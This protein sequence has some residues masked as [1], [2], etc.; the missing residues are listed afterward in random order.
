MKKKTLGIFIDGTMI[1]AALVSKDADQLIVEKVESFKLVEAIEQPKSMATDKLGKT[2]EP[3]TIDFDDNPWQTDESGA[4]SNTPV[5]QEEQTNLDIVREILN[6]MCPKGTSIAF[7][8]CES[9]VFYKT[10]QTIHES[11][12]R[13][14]KEEIWN[15]FYE[16]GDAKPHLENVGFLQQNSGS[17]VALIHND[18]LTL[19]SLLFEL[20]N[21]SNI[22]PPRIQLVD[23]I[24]FTLAHEI[25]ETLNIEE[26]ETS[27]VV[28]FSKSFT[29]VFFM[30]GEKI[31]TVLPPILEGAKSE[32]VCETTFSK[33]LFEFSSG[34]IGVITRMVLMGEYEESKA[35]EFFMKKFPNLPIQKFAT[36]RVSISPEIK[37]TDHLNQYALPILLAAKSLD[38]KLS[39]PYNLNFLPR[40]IQDK[41]S[42]YKIAWHGIAMLAIV[43][44]CAFLMTMQ[45]VKNAQHISK[46]KTDISYLKM[47]AQQL[48]PVENESDSLLA[49]ISK[50]EKQTSLLDSLVKNTTRWS[51][52]LETF[53]NAYGKI[54]SFSL[55][56]LISQAHNQLIADAIMTKREQV[57]ELERAINNSMILNVTETQSDINNALNLQIQCKVEKGN[58]Q[59]IEKTG[60]IKNKTIK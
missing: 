10:I 28:F 52:A 8:L 5:L 46:T 47:T 29:K 3:E 59:E 49:N 32:K 25:K 17:L 33:I 23:S 4:E 15:I 40:R 45:L 31:I 7:N 50:L 42:V 37:N 55:K 18:P 16:E 38:K 53:S 19:S 56:S 41:Q 21:I 24:E 20:K 2:D 51:P 43:F 60:Q 13:K 26:E 30:H 11:R 9:H 27:L 1:R 44:I 48:A 39:A 35:F 6:K 36:G 57:A 34:K 22:I 12:P 54:G 14:I 58:S